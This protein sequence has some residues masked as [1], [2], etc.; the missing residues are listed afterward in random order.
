MRTIFVL[1]PKHDEITENLSLFFKALYNGFINRYCR[2]FL[3]I[4]EGD[5]DEITT[6]GL[7]AVI[8]GCDHAVVIGNADENTI[9]GQE[10]EPLLSMEDENSLK[11]VEGS[12]VHLIGSKSGLKLLPTLT[13]KYNVNGFGYTDDFFFLYSPK[14]FKYI[15]P[16]FEAD[17]EVE[18]SLLNGY[19]YGNTY[20]NTKWKYQEMLEKAPDICKPFLY[21][22]MKSLVFCGDKEQALKEKDTIFDTFDFIIRFMQRIVSEFVLR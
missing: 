15:H 3:D 13:E 22:N 21:H 1:Y 16:F 5:R 9:R 11:L 19:T 7:D 8:F 12:S 2:V 14:T 18:R 10:N 20:D 17:A 6:L 4:F